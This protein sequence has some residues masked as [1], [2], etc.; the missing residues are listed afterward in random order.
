MKKIIICNPK[1]PKIKYIEELE[2]G[3]VM[4]LAPFNLHWKWWRKWK[5]VWLHSHEKLND[6]KPL[7]DAFVIEAVHLLSKS[8]LYFLKPLIDSY[9]NVICF[10]YAITERTKKEFEKILGI[11]PEFDNIPELIKEC[12]IPDYKITIHKCS[13]DNTKKLEG[14][15]ERERYDEYEEL[16]QIDLE[17]GNGT[18]MT[19]YKLISFFNQS[20]GKINKVNDL[21]KEWKD[22]KVIVFNSSFRGANR[23]NCRAYSLKSVNKKLIELFN[24]NKINHLAFNSFPEF[25]MKNVQK[26]V[27]NMCHINPEI[28]ANLIYQCYS[29]EWNT[30]FK[31][32][33][34][35]IVITD[36]EYEEYKIN[37]VLELFE[38]DKI[39]FK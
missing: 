1:F 37:Q 18:I 35:H 29:L 36:Q 10:S 26:V 11:T 9:E 39:K 15:T 4:V 12:I 19:E 25:E 7:G 17:L 22:E 27:I 14:L 30:S 13:L 2:L 5:D 20:Y 24:N 33:D 21:L 3:T 38:S 28:I 34:I 6:F 32:L 8:E 31:L 23:L 16:R